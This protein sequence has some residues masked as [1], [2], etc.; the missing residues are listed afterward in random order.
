MSDLALPIIVL[1]EQ[2][3]WLITCQIISSLCAMVVVLESSS[4]SMEL[5]IV[6]SLDDEKDVEVC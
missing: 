6:V 4:Y 1:K 3:W 5:G 2:N